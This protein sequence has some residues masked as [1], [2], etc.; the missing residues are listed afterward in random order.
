MNIEPETLFD[1]I[2]GASKEIGDIL[3]GELSL[4]FIASL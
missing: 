4:I 1:R 3:R 2:D